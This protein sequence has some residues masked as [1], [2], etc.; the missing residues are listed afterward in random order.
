MEICPKAEAAGEINP[1]AE[2]IITGLAQNVGKNSDPRYIAREYR[3]K[4]ITY[5]VIVKAY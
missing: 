3:S 2:Q 5:E 4:S 1:V